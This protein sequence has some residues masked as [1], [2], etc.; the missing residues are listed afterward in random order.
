MQKIKFNKK[1]NQILFYRKK[2]LSRRKIIKDANRIASKSE[3]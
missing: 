1:K 2:K 3:P